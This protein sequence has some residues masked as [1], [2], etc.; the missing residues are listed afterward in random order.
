MSYLTARYQ[1]ICHPQPNRYT[2]DR[3]L[4]AKLVRD[5]VAQ[6]VREGGAD[7]IYHDDGVVEY[8]RRNDRDVIEEFQEEISLGRIFY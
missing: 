5:G 8:V 4:V 1:V 7:T 6:Y 2:D 3:S